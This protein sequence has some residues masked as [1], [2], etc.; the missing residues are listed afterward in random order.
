[1]FRLILILIFALVST[2]S[3]SQVG[4]GN[5]HSGRALW[6]KNGVVIND[7]QGRSVRQNAKVVCLDDNSSIIVWEDERNGYTDIYAQRLASGGAK[8][9]GKGG[10]GVCEAPGNQTA[11]QV[12]SDGKS[13]MIVWQDYRNGNADI[14]V[15]KLNMSGSAIW[16]KDG[17]PV[18][19]VETNQLEP[20]LAGNGAGGAI[21]TWYDYRSGRGEDVYA[22]KISKTGSAEWQANGAPVCTEE[23]TQ[24]HPKI[25]SDGSGGAVICWDDKRGDYYDTYAQRLD[26]NGN[27]VW[28]VDGIAVCAAPE[29]QEYSQIASCEGDSFVITWQDYRNG[30]ADIYAQKINLDGRILWKTNGE[31]VCDVAGNQERPQIVGGQDP[32]IIWS[33]FRNGTGNSDIFCQKMSSTGTPLWDPYGIS[34]C[35]ASGNQANLKAVSDGMDGAVITWQDQRSAQG[36]I[37][38]RRVTKDGKALWTSDGMTVCKGNN[39]EFPQIS[40]SKNGNIIIV[41]QD[42]RNGGLD[43]YAQGID[44]NK[45]ESWKNNGVEIV[46]GFGS[47]TQQKPRIIRTGREE[48]V[49]AWEDYRNGYSNVFV[50]RINNNGKLLWARDGIR[51]C[52]ADC[53]QYNPQLVSDDDGGAIIVWEDNRSGVSTI[54]AQKID[55]YGNILWD[56]GGIRLCQGEGSEVNPK[57]SKNS[58]GG[59][60]V[61]WQDSRKREGLFNIYAQ[62]ID[63]N[64]SLLWRTDGVAVKYSEGTQ[65]NLDIDSDG[66]DG[67]VITWEEY[68]Q[69]FNTPDIHAQK[70]SGSGNI[71]WTKT[72]L[73]VCKAPESQKQPNISVNNEIIIAW[74]DNSG[75]S[76]DIY[77]QKLSKDGTIAWTCDGVPV[78]TEPSTQINPKVITDGDG[79]AIFVWEDYRKANWDIYAQRL[80]AAGK[81]MWAKYGVEVCTAAGTQYSPQLVKSKELSTIITW[82]DYRNNKS[83]NIYAQKLSGSG[84][85]LWEKD[86]LPLCVTEGGARNPQLADDGE[87]GAVVVWT[88]Y[89]YGSYDIYAQRIN[90]VENK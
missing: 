22:Q 39:A 76:Y 32:I 24:W 77:T 81:Q 5:H 66:E 72:G 54:Y 41:W 33:D 23:G 85:V 70:I 44:M 12:I 56:G 10:V 31:T 34:I 82:E 55:P 69:N 71:M 28:Q 15:Q 86:G 84:E 40:L 87:G 74:E 60:I 65:M 50:Q 37:F 78:C 83:Y 89:R 88:D 30:N 35:E 67:A 58:K 29:N 3:F 80:N 68:R 1:M 57:L 8:L 79:G 20:Q 42:K 53:D 7:S 38:A 25:V 47:V 16:P 19:T 26:A 73:S 63:K 62:G 21:I 36:A 17:I 11:P 27:P 13:A 49:V 43:V 2:P 75:G 90:E 18:C 48:Y 9:W 51:I 61:A 14:Y 64:G 52:N 45:L 6:Q 4:S 59:A 46:L